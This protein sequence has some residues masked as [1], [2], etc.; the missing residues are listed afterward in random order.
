MKIIHTCDLNFVLLNHE[1]SFSRLFS[2]RKINRYKWLKWCKNLQ[3]AKKL[4]LADESEGKDKS[5][6]RLFLPLHRSKV[7]KSRKVWLLWP[8]I[9]VWLH[10]C[11]V[12]KFKI[13]PHLKMNKSFTCYQQSR[14]LKTTNYLETI[15][16]TRK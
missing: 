2:A 15:W 10:V 7:T 1:S 4:T 3:Y 13:W 12:T 9:K 8:R 14:R 16:N 11:L 6:N 5:E